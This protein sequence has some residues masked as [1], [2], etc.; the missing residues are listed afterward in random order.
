[1]EKKR[2]EWGQT[3]WDSM[4]KEDLIREVQRMYSAVGSL[5]SCLSMQKSVCP[6]SPYWGAGGAG[7]RALSK[8]DQVQQSVEKTYDRDDLYR[9]FYRY[10]D[11]LLFN[12]V[13]FGW[14]ICPKCGM[15]I[16]AS[17]DGS[18]HTGKMCGDAIGMQDGTCTGI[19]RPIQWDDIRKSV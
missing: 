10:A 3:P 5:E 18:R 12:G 1:M 11:D 9:S 6:E 19:L 15:M 7:G 17:I 2:L 16:G 13:G 14:D 8:A 4:S